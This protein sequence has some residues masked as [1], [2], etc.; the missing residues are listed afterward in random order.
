MGTGSVIAAG[1][2]QRMSAGTGIAHSEFNDSSEEPVHLFQIW[3]TPREQGIE[4]SYQQS[5]LPDGSPGLHLVAGPEGSDAPLCLHQDAKLFV[6]ELGTGQ[7]IQYPLARSRGAWIQVARGSVTL[8]GQRLQRGDGAAVENED[9]L[10]LKG[11]EP[12]E[13]LVFDLA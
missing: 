12:A 4:P 8:N 5:R 11:E 6:A 3:I 10:L 7:R 9:E 2:V 1:E 13:V